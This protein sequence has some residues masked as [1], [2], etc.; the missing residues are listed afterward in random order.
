[1]EKE[2]LSVIDGIILFVVIIVLFYAFIIQKVLDEYE[3]K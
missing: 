2:C 1:M 3:K